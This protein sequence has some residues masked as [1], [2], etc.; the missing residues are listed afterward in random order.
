MVRFVQLESERLAAFRSAA[1]L[2]CAACAA[3]YACRAT[4]AWGP[5]ESMLGAAQEAVEGDAGLTG[6]QA[7]A[8]A[9]AVRATRRQLTAARL[10]TKHGLPTPVADVRDSDRGAAE[11]LVRTLL[12]RVARSKNTESR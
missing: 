12:A 5:L 3:V 9:A 6:P 11:R 10:L 2:A 1:D 4:D 7:E 8:A